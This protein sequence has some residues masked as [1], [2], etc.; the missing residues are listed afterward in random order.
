MDP[1]LV[2]LH[3]VSTGL[4]NDELT[5]LKFLCRGRVGKRKL[6]RVHSG[7]DL[8]NVL[9]EQNELDSEHTEL[10]RELLVSLRRQDLLQRLDNFEAG[11]AGRAPPEERDL[12]AAFDIICDN[13]GKDW[14]RLARH[15]KVTDAKIDAIEEKYPRNL[16]EQ[17]RESLRVWKSTKTEEA[18]V[19]HLV[20]VLR[21]CQLNL[22][23]DLIVEHQQAQGLENENENE[24]SRGGGGSISVSL[25]SWDSDGPALGASW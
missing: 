14:R 21:A 16:T 4:S 2:L 18:T 15:L 22:V 13:V 3:S 7:L 10:L 8:F 20:R 17:V 12:R 19:S 23:A 25:T 24:S 1:F 5:E 6:E 11:A 9:L